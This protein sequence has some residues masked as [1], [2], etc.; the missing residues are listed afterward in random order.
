MEH[1]Q[2]AILVCTKMGFFLSWFQNG[3]S[4]KKKKPLNR[5][6]ENFTFLPES[7]VTK[8]N[9]AFTLQSI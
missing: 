4:V 3:C 6:T 7:Y 5:G 2:A 8:K 1:L 9:N